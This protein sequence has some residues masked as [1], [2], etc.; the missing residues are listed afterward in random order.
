[1]QQTE[2]ELASRIVIEAIAKRLLL[3]ADYNGVALHLAPH[4][5]YERHDDLHIGAINTAKVWKEGEAP[6]LGSFKLAGLRNLALTAD[7][8][9]PVAG[10]GQDLPREG[11]K[12]ILAV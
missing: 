3:R 10:L 8:F 1:M 12:L 2:T 9:E 7:P 11:D 5:L 4:Q 6:R